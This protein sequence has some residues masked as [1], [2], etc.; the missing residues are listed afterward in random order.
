MRLALYATR[1]FVQV[2]QGY[3]PHEDAAE[4]LRRSRR[5]L[6]WTLAGGTAG[7]LL[8]A[9]LAPWAG[10]LL[11]GGELHI[12]FAVSISL[13]F[14]LAAMLISQVTGFT[15]LTTYRRNSALAWSTVAGAMVGV[16]GLVPAALT[17]GVAGVTSVLAVSEVVV[18]A[19]Q[20][21]VLGSQF[22]QRGLT[23]E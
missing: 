7:G 4:Q 11:S 14:A 1:P 22:R 9:A 13:G 16:V 6:R 17:F 21:V 8:Y 5:T 12:S 20:C 10:L 19:Y 23:S 15:I 18:L 2:T 3:V